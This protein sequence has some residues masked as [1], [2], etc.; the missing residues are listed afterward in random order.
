[1]GLGTFGLF[2]HMGGS[3]K[4]PFTYVENCAEAIALAG[5]VKGVDGQV[6]NVVDDDLPSSRQFLRQ[7][8]QNV[9]SFK[10]L[11]VPHVL[12]H[13][14][15]Y[16]WEKY[17]SW[18]QGQLPPVFNRRRWSVEWKKTRYSNHKLKTQLGWAPRISTAD[19]MQIYFDSCARSSRDA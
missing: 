8:K 9:R 3:N 11:Y 18:S 15:C 1:V 13:A 12:S 2:L 5:L 10:S 7:Y 19:G 6:F 17:S 4:V 14:L 16:L